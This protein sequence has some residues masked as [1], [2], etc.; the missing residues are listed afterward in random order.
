MEKKEQDR[1]LLAESFKDEQAYNK[2]KRRG[3][4]RLDKFFNDLSE[5]IAGWLDELNGICLKHGNYLSAEEIGMAHDNFRL[6]TELRI[7]LMDESKLIHAIMA[8]R[9]EFFERD[10]R[11]KKKIEQFIKITALN[12]QDVDEL[13]EIAKKRREERVG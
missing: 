4:K 9:D 11:V 5:G 10:E 7:H 12:E 3:Q 2:I 1:S 8:L 13:L 6:L